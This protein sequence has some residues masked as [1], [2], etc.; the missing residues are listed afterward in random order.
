MQ[1]I[2]SRKLYGKLNSFMGTMRDGTARKM[3]EGQQALIDYL[4]TKL[5]IYEEKFAE[6]TGKERPELTDADRARLARAALPQRR[7]VG[8]ERAYV[9]AEDVHGLVQGA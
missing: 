1:T 7:P 9:V 6:A 5:S 8:A 2:T 3:V 4:Q